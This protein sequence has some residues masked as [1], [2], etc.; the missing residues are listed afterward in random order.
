MER[1]FTAAILQMKALYWALGGTVPGF[2][3]GTSHSIN[4][5]VAEGLY[6]RLRRFIPIHPAGAVYRQVCRCKMGDNKIR[7]HSS[8]TRTDV[9]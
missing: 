6:A 8:L 9:I 1:K 2:G 7:F 5:Y 4:L 3:R